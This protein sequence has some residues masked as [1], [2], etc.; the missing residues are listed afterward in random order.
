MFGEL[1]DG[2]G[3]PLHLSSVCF[4]AVLSS[5]RGFGISV[6]IM[7]VEMSG[8]LRDGPTPPPLAA[9]KSKL[10][11]SGCR[12][13]EGGILMSRGNL[14]DVLSQRISVWRILVG[15]LGVRSVLKSS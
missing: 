5:S 4:R 10:H 1:R 12:T 6:S 11:K 13:T 3:E 14:P 15:R 2:Q 7:L 8:K 9:S